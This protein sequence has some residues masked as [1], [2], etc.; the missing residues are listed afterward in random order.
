MVDFKEACVLY[1]L[2]LLCKLFIFLGHFCLE[3]FNLLLERHHEEG[4]SLVSLRCLHD[5][6]KS[7]T[8]CSILLCILNE[9]IL[10]QEVFNGTFFATHFVLKNL[11]LSLKLC[12]L[13]F[14]C[15]SCLLDLKHFLLELLW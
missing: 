5:G 15:I 9:L 6:C 2:L 12:V 10:L 7:P 1:I 3:L 8:V 14:I 13:L 11:D 4:L